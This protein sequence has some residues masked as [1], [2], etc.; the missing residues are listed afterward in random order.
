[1]ICAV[2]GDSFY[3]QTR[4]EPAEPCDCGLRETLREATEEDI[5]RINR[6][7]ATWIKHGRDWPDESPVEDDPEQ[8]T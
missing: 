7:R 8:P 2:C 6:L 4:W 3:D 5:E 1:M